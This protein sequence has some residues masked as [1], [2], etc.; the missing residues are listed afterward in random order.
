MGRLIVAI[1]ALIFSAACNGGAL[2]TDGGADLAGADL[3]GADLAGADLAPSP[4]LTSGAPGCDGARAGVTLSG[5]VQPILS[6]HC[7]GLECHGNF[8]AAGK[9]F[10]D[11]VGQPASECQDGRLLVS[12]GAPGQSYVYQ[13]VT[14]ADLCAGEKMPRFGNA[15]DAAELQTI[16]DWICDG[17]SND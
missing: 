9:T 2:V 1:A 3:A 11:V 12:P 4:D 10:G 14:G 7:S 15:L 8:F 13:K 6:Q 16:H 5:D 17:A